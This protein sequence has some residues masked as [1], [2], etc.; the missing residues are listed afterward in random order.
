MAPPPGPYSGT[1]TL[2]LVARAS[3]FTF[4]IVYGSVK[5]KYLKVLRLFLC[6]HFEAIRSIRLEEEGFCVGLFCKLTLPFDTCQSSSRKLGKMLEKLN[7][8]LHVVS[9]GIQDILYAGVALWASPLFKGINSSD[10]IKDW[11]AVSMSFP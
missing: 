11:R 1:S 7:F 3:A 8:A 10:V 5:L 6:S 9:R 4:G 2:A